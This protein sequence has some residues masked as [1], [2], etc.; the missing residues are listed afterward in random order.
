MTSGQLIYKLWKSLEYELNIRNQVLSKET[1]FNIES[2]IE[3]HL[4]LEKEIIK[5]LCFIDEYNTLKDKLGN[6]T[7]NQAL[8]EETL[9][10][11]VKRY[12]NLTSKQT[13]N[14]QSILLAIDQIN[15]ALF[16]DVPV[17]TPI[18]LNIF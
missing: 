9:K 17:S 7:R 6:Y 14:E 12:E 1:K 4:R 18:N 15:S 8:S 5:T 2:K 11:I 3:K 13:T 16:D 10:K